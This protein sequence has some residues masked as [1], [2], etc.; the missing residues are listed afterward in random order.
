MGFTFLNRALAFDWRG[1]EFSDFR[2]NMTPITTLGVACD[3]S[4]DDE[5][6]Y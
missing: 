4:W 2:V 6:V 3:I 1:R 5:I